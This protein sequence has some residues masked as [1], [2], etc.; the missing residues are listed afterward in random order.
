MVTAAAATV[1]PTRNCRREN[2]L[3]IDVFR[4][5]FSSSDSCF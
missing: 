5:T 2:P 1:L 4:F 3:R